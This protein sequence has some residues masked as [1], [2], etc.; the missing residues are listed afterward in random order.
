MLKNLNSKEVCLLY[1]TRKVE[2]TKSKLDVDPACDNVFIGSALARYWV[3][4]GND[5]ISIADS[6][7]KSIA[8]FEFDPKLGL[9][10]V[11]GERNN[12]LLVPST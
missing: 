2:P 5:S 8:R 3:D 7:G 12:L 11:K 4:H 9:Q 1:K 10:T 6:T